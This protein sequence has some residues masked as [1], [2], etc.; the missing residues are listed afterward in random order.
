MHACERVRARSLPLSTLVFAERAWALCAACVPAE[1]GHTFAEKEADLLPWRQEA[2]VL[3]SARLRVRPAPG[4]RMPTGF[5]VGTKVS[6]KRVLLLSVMLV[7][8]RA[9]EEI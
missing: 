2:D 8:S 6:V 3:C 5:C 9:E 4:C 1:C 7:S